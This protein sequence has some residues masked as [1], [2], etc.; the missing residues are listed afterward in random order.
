MRITTGM[1]TSG[2]SKSL[3]DQLERLND[4]YAKATT[5]HS[6]QRASDDPA[7]ASRA[8]RA[9]RNV[10]A[11]AAQKD[12]LTAA[13][14]WVSSTDSTLSVLNTIAKSAISSLTSVSNGTLS[15]DGLSTYAAQLE[16]QQQELLSTL[17]TTYGSRY[18]FG[19]SA[20]GPVPF[21]V[22]TADDGADNVGKLMIY[23]Y[24]AGTPG[25]IAFSSITADKAAQ[26]N[27]T[28]PVDVGFGMKADGGSGVVADTAMDIQANPVQMLVASFSSTGNSNLF[29]VLGSAIGKLKAGGTPDVSDELTLAQKSQDAILTA[30]VGVG[31]LGNTISFLSD[32]NDTFSESAQTQLS[33]AEDIDLTKAILE[34]TNRQTVY[35]AALA[36]GTKII[37]PT[38]MDFLK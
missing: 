14:T 3:S 22:G 13:K 5:Q 24:N 32:R 18:L 16:S 20:T 21:K 33:A 10:S 30:Y 35:N 6:F 15:D 31:E 17:N 8:L 29:D 4:S 19:G 23:D 36:M 25:Y 9:L 28:M 12:N 11:L 38:L 7:S 27:L 37:Q 26:M 1:L 2:Y 34:Y